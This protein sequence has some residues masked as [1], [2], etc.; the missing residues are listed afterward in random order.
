MTEDVSR[1][2][3]GNDAKFYSFGKWTYPGTDFHKVIITDK[4]GRKREK[5]C[6]Q[7]K[8]SKGKCQVDV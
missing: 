3:A 5:D 8:G 2:L 6:K 4:Y 1:V 7:I